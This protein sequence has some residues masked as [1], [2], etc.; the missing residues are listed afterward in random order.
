VLRPIVGK[1]F[2]LFIKA[3][4]VIIAIDGHY[5]YSIEDLRALLRGHVQG[6]RL[7]IRYRRDRLTY[8]N[9]LALKDAGPPK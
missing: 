9:Y 7:A 2:K 8:E 6:G 5:L 3:G 4:D 1:P